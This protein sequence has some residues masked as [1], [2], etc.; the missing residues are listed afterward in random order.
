MPQQPISQQPAVLEVILLDLRRRRVPSR[1]DFRVAEVFVELLPLV[2][3]EVQQVA[4]RGPNA[5]VLVLLAGRARLVEVL[6]VGPPEGGRRQ[7]QLP[8]LE[9]LDVLHAALA[10][11]ALA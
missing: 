2:F 9:G 1:D 7:L 6:A 11:A 3:G 5:P 4:L 10:V 8:A